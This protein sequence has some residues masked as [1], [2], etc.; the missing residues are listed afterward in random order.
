MCISI[1]RYICNCQYLLIESYGSY[2]IIWQPFA[3]NSFFCLFIFLFSIAECS[4]ICI[5]FRGSP[6][7]LL[8]AFAH[9]MVNGPTTTC[10]EIH[11]DIFVRSQVFVV[12]IRVIFVPRYQR[13]IAFPLRFQTTAQKKSLFVLQF[14]CCIEKLRFLFVGLSST[15]GRADSC[16]GKIHSETRKDNSPLLIWDSSFKPAAACIYSSVMCIDYFGSIIIIVFSFVLMQNQIFTFNIL[17]IFSI[18]N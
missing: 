8:G 5:D 16:H 12:V 13:S 11:I 15:T 10:L 9:P 6:L 17:K 1:Y 18:L 3:R 2:I 7:L 4:T 14:I